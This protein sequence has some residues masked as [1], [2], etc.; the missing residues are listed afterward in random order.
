MEANELQSILDFY[1]EYNEKDRL[2]SGEGKLE[3]LR[4]WELLERYLPEAPA[5]LL[6][7]GGATGVYA[8]PLSERGYKVHLI[9]VVPLHI[10]QAK[11][12][13]NEKGVSLEQ[14]EVGDA[15][16]LP[17]AD[18]SIDAVLMLGPLYHLPDAEERRKA[19]KEAFRVL[20]PGGVLFAA[21]ISRF[22]STLDSFRYDLM[23]KSDYVSSVRM[24]VTN[25]KR[26]NPA[27]Y[28]YKPEELRLEIETAGFEIEALVAI[29]GNAWL[30]PKLNEK[31]QDPALT[32]RILAVLRELEREPSLLGSSP[33]FMVIS[34][35]N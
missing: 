16:S 19:I 32:E 27:A 15:R 8:F 10:Q 21:G 24:S 11:D 7:I 17:L 26:T 31:L 9:D 34:K 29:E 20:R 35:R 5:T 33:H 1:A 28:T 22:T 14:I 13:S 25:G 6:D 18:E 4:T 30:V 23:D 2:A 12:I 3:Y